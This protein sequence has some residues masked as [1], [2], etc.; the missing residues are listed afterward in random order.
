[1]KW[2]AVKRRWPPPDE[3]SGS[4]LSEDDLIEAG[5]KDVIQWSSRMW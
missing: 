1:M 5:E 4:A 2:E 3:D